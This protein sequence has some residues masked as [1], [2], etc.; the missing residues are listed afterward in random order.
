MEL[1]LIVA[2]RIRQRLPLKSASSLPITWKSYDFRGHTVLIELTRLNGRALVVNCDLIK[3]IE[4]AP[5]TMLTL[6]TGEKIVV[7]ESCAD[8]VARA[9]AYRARLLQE[10]T[11][12]GGQ[13]A[14]VHAAAEGAASAHRSFVLPKAA[15]DEAEL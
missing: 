11:S 12:G 9:T 6:V 3:Y 5:D 1:R 15:A 14:A 2:V 7:R 8:V 13:S 4:S 10:I